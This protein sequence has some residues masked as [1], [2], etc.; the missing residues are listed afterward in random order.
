M[1]QGARARVLRRRAKSICAV[2]QYGSGAKIVSCLSSAQHM[3][4]QH[5]DVFDL[6]TGQKKEYNIR[7]FESQQS[8]KFN[9]RPFISGYTCP[10]TPNFELPA[11]N[12]A[13]ISNLHFVPGSGP[14]AGS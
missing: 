3:I 9:Q 4:V 11:P 12:F 10:G 14:G 1:T 8:C 13:G 7:H 5:D 6:L 2:A